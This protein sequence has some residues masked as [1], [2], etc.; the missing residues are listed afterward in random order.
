LR[1]EP[2]TDDERKPLENDV[3]QVIL[4]HLRVSVQRT[5]QVFVKIG[6]ANSQIVP[7]QVGNEWA[8]FCE[9][10]EGRFPSDARWS[11]AISGRPWEDQSFA[12]TKDQTITVNITLEGGGKK[13]NKVAVWIELGN[14]AKEQVFLIWNIKECWDDFRS[15]VSG[16]LEH[17]AWSARIKSPD[18]RKKGIPWF[19]NS[20]KPRKGELIEVMIL[21]EEITH[22]DLDV[23]APVPDRILVHP[24]NNI[25]D[26]RPAE[27]GFLSEAMENMTLP[28]NW[29]IREAEKATNRQVL[30][31]LFAIKDWAN[32]KYAGLFLRNVI[33]AARFDDRRDRPVGVPWE[34]IDPSSPI[35][36]LLVQIP[37]YKWPIPKRQQIR[38]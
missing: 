5:V 35:S 36:A 13:T 3:V 22:V 1:G 9:W 17:D 31:T 16:E 11:A 25:L 18:G 38:R 28:P 7:L 14:R 6:T 19:D 23:S 15:K 29:V 8:R 21:D 4:A 27:L 32:P 2:W 12:P 34:P 33:A 37:L 30:L 26:G 10:M 20:I 24:K